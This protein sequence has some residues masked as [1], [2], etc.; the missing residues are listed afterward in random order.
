MFKKCQPAT[1]APVA[2]SDNWSSTARAPPTPCSMSLGARELPLLVVAFAGA[3]RLHFCATA[4]RRSAWTGGAPSG[5]ASGRAGGPANPSARAPRQPRAIHP[6]RRARRTRPRRS[7]TGRLPL[8]TNRFAGRRRRRGDAA[9]R[10]AAGR[11][12]VAAPLGRAR[13]PAARRY[14]ARSPSH[15]SSSLPPIWNLS[16]RSHSRNR[17]TSSRSAAIRVIVRDVVLRAALFED[18]LSPRLEQVEWSARRG[19]R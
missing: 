6:H 9:R 19:G 13:S 14:D 2:A 10:S 17:S 7:R 3:S 4:K 5:A 16:T 8:A 11:R 1:T 18:R 12:H 15:S